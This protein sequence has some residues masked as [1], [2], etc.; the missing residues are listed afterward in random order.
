MGSS[1]LGF[2]CS[3]GDLL[4]LV[5]V[6]GRG[7]SSGGLDP[8]VLDFGN[9]GFD[10]TLFSLVCRGGSDGGTLVFAFDLHVGLDRVYRCLLGAADN[11]FIVVEDFPVKGLGPATGNLSV[12]WWCQWE[13]VEFAQSKVILKSPFDVSLD[14]FP[15]S[16]V[17]VIEWFRLV[18]DWTSPFSNGNSGGPKNQPFG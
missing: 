15:V 2:G 14:G 12:C 6:S 4:G 11:F 7:T 9:W 10:S 8:G 5:G 1:D 16:F 13:T 3:K 17:F 18:V